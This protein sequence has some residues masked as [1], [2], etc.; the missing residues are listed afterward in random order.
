M[1]VAAPARPARTAVRSAR[2]A[3]L[4]TAGLVDSFGMT[5]GWTVFSLLVLDTGG[6][7]AVGVCNAAM[8]VGVALSAPATAWLSGRL[9]T[10]RLLR[11]AS[12]TEAVL[13]VASFLLLLSGASLAVLAAVIAVM[14]AAGLAAY[15]GM[16]AE[17]SAA[18]RPGRHGATMTSFVVAIMAAEAAGVTCAALLPGQPPGTAGGV[19][20]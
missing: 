2:F 14:Y 19:L 11:V 15:A 10:R 16:R 20:A 4:L 18:S 9:D 7:V 8:L 12:G 1:A 17:V 5:F 3:H 13:R 6:L